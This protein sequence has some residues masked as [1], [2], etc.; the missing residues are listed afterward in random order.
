[1]LQYPL[2]KKCNYA[3]WSIRMCVN[4][5][6]KGVWDAIKHG[7]EVEE[8]KDRMTLAAIYEIVSEDVL[9]MLAEK[10]SAK[11]AWETLQTM[12]VGVE[13]V[14]EAKVQTSSRISA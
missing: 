12:H 4:L 3:A 9:L 1:M 8:H 6:A 13:R 2:L 5:K 7:D 14:N 10:D 11:V